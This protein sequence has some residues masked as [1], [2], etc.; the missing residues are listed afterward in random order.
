MLEYLKAHIFDGI[1]KKISDLFN[2]LL[3]NKKVS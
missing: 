1:L 3:H 2:I